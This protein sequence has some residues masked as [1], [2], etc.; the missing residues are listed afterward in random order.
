[1]AIANA[2]P[3]VA[4][5]TRDVGKRA[6]G[7]S[8]AGPG[9]NSPI[10]AAPATSKSRTR[11]VQGGNLALMIGYYVHH[12]GQGHLQRAM[13]IAPYLSD[14]MTIFSSLPRPSHWTGPW[15]DLPRDD[16][17]AAPANPTANGQLHWAPT[18]DQGLATRMAAIAAWISTTQP[19]CFVVD[20]SVEVCAFVRLMGVPLV[21]C[22]QPGDRS[23]RAHQL[24]YSLADLIIVPW[25]A[26]MTAQLAPGLGAWA[27]KVRVVGAFSRFD[28]CDRF[29]LAAEPTVTVLQGAGGTQVGATHVWAARNTTPGWTWTSIGGSDAWVKDPWELLCRS[30]V[31]VS[32]AGMNSLAEIAAAGRPAIIIAQE[33]PHDEQR[34]TA[35][36]L[37]RAG[38]AVVCEQWPSAAKWPTVLEEAARLDPPRWQSWSFGDGAQ[39]A[40][41]AINGV[42]ES[43]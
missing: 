24:G 9:H 26:A 41:A 32:H 20:V 10:E 36:A 12:V 43:A 16:S 15:I 14:R 17:C 19:S 7:V 40:A 42:I 35:R 28:G 6:V 23:D 33:R 38:I 37:E 39:R 34:T 29:A 18:R 31:V 4:P 5:R 27:A 11:P 22:A 13:A 8:V 2:Y 1:V 3:R 21:T 30:H 25:P